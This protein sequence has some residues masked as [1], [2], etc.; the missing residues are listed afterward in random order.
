M[1]LTSR[2]TSAPVVELTEVELDRLRTSAETMRDDDTTVAGRIRIL[3][4]DG[5]I[6]V[7]EQT[8]QRHFLVR[9]MPSLECAHT[10]VDDRLAVYDKMWDG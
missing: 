10:F 9:A 6:L 1:E 3:S 7:Q 5:M 8:P 4:F 2:L